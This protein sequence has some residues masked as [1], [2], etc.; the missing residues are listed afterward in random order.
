MEASS[1]PLRILTFANSEASEG[2]TFARVITP[3]CALQ[4][5][6]LVE[7]TFVR[8]IWSLILTS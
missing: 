8:T 6:G 3:L 1:K 2:C 5:D 7:F 4:K